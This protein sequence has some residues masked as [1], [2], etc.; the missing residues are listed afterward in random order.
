[1]FALASTLLAMAYAAGVNAA[2]CTALGYVYM[3]I[4]ALASRCFFDKYYIWVEWFGLIILTFA[5]ALFGFLNNFYAGSAGQ[6]NSVLAMVLV[7]ASACTSV[8]ASLSAE[9]VLKNTDETVEDL[10]FHVQK[11]G[12]DIG[13]AV[14]TFLLFF[15]IGGISTR[16]QDAFWK[17]RPLDHDCQVRMPSNMT[18]ASPDC[19]CECGSGIFVAWGDLTVII[20]LL[21]NVLQGWLT[22]VVIKQFSTVLRAIAQSS[23]ILAIYFVGDPVL[24][25]DSVRNWV[26]TLVAFVVPLSTA[27]FMTAAAEMEKVMTLAV[28]SLNPRLRSV[29]C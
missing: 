1:L 23:T 26:L 5:S 14:I 18:C 4:S 22:G 19:I 25:P 12:L 28:A 10:P 17:Q 13:S 15:V 29:T 16:P 7:V 24:N 9:K 8:F 21:I 27:L 2:V 20:A 11:V 3:P 6:E